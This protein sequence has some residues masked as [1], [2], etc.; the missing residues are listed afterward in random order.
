VAKTQK[1][2][3][4]ATEETVNVLKDLIVAKRKSHINVLLRREGDSVRYKFQRL[5]H[6]R[7]WF[8]SGIAYWQ[9]RLQG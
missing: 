9:Q 7:H 8:F 6:A 2:E 4:T 5:A 3:T 1:P